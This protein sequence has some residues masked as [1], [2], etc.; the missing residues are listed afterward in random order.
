MIEGENMTG[1]EAVKQAIAELPVE[2][3]TGTV[4]REGNTLTVAEFLEQNV[5]PYMDGKT[6]DDV[7]I[8]FLQLCRMINALMRL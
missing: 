3:V 2:I 5:A 6:K 4:S 8:L 7:I 1:I